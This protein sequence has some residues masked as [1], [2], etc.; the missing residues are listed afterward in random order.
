MRMA[1]MWGNTATR[2]APSSRHV[3]CTYR[4]ICTRCD[5]CSNVQLMPEPASTSNAWPVCASHTPASRNAPCVDTTPC[6]LYKYS[7][8]IRY[9]NHTYSHMPPPHMFQWTFNNIWTA[10]CNCKKSSQVFRRQTARLKSE[11]TLKI[12][13]KLSTAQSTAIFRARWKTKRWEHTA[14]SRFLISALSLSSDPSCVAVSWLESQ[15]LFL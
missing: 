3:E 9:G 8:E 14:P 1:G 11:I 5:L 4:K 6:V 13:T 7:R 12:G 15:K 2:P 10:L